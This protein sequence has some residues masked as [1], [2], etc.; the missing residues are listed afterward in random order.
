M[1]QEHDRAPAAS[2][3]FVS[4]PSLGVDRNCRTS[5]SCA[6]A[7]NEATE[8]MTE[9]GVGTQLNIDDVCIGVVV[10]ASGD[11]IFIKSD[12]FTGWAWKDEIREA[13]RSAT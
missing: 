5:Q 12:V 6:A 9:L 2:L 7:T 11:R 13:M 10:E 1:T 3:G 4:V 8:C